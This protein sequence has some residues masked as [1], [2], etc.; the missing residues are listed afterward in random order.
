[1]RTYD[2]TFSGARIYPGKV[3]TPP[4]S[5][6]LLRKTM[7]EGATMRC[8]FGIGEYTEEG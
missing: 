8:I 4:N 6:A 2:D 7:N 3:R 1:M 5:V